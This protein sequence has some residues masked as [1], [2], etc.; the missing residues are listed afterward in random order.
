MLKTIPGLTLVLLAVGAARPADPVRLVSAD[1]RQVVF[2]LTVDSFAVA[3]TKDGAAVTATGCFSLANPG[4]PDLPGR[5]VMVGLPPEG[6]VRVSASASETDARSGLAV[7]P[8]PD[9]TKTPDAGRQTPDAGARPAAE[10]LG[11]ERFRD[12]RVARVRVNPAR[13]DPGT[14]AVSLSHRV[15][16]TVAFDNAGTGRARP[17]GLDPALQAMLV[18]GTQAL[19][20]KL[21]P[22]RPDTLNFFSRLSNWCRIETET[23]GVY[24]VTPAELQA[25]GFDPAAI[26]PAALRLFALGPHTINGPYP[27]TMIEMPLLSSDNGDARFEGSEY[28]AFYAEA[29]SGWRD[30]DTLWEAN[31]FTRYSVYWL[32]WGTG[33]GLRMEDVDGAGASDGRTTALRRVRLEEDLQCPSRSG[34]LWLW[35]YYYKASGV[36]SAESSVVLNLPG[37]D[38]AGHGFDVGAGFDSAAGEFQLRESGSGV[39][40]AG[41]CAGQL[42][43]GAVH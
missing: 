15:V 7:R 28:V 23:T 24:R 41:G 21:E 9:W 27:D 16:V 40:G 2:E 26:D 10:L 29:P 32:G 8:R 1:G 30:V 38:T 5:I 39:C 43:A 4:E 17:D 25:A 36:L 6:N 14:R 18:N 22:L 37:R 12:L 19:Q 3:E 33:A 20:W 13:Y 34:L 11:I 35:A 42:E 31:P